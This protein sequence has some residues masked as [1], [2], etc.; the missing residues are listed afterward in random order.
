MVN[1]PYF[2]FFSVFQIYPLWIA[3][4]VLTFS[5][6]LLLVVNFVTMI[7]YDLDF[8]ASSRDHDEFPPVPSWVWLMCA[9]NN[10]LSHTLGKL[11][12]FCINCHFGDYHISSVKRQSFF[13]PNQSQKSRSIL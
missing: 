1:F 5:G 3:P 10:F 11:L 12:W 7:Y 2:A 6:F 8:Y 4:N 13:L 9:I